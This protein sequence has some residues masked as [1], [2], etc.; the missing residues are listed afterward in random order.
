MSEEI[1]GRVPEKLSQEFSRTESRILGALSTLDEFLL[2]PLERTWS[3]NV[4]GTSWN[5]GSE[6]REHT[7]DRSLNDLYPEVEFSVRQ[8]STSAD[9]DREE[10]SHNNCM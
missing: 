2:N 7:G 4:P 6:N 9:S 3:G 8:A 10:T 1:E 5:N